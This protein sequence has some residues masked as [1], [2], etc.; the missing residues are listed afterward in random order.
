M[1]LNIAE[2]SYETGE[3]R[4]RY[5][6]YLSPDGAR[7]IRHGLFTEF[8]RNGQ[9]ASQGTYEDGFEEGS[10]QDFYESGQI[11]AEGTYYRGAEVG[12]LRYWNQDGIEEIPEN[13]G[14]GPLVE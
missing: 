14:D 9:L 11:A 5:A 6:R 13:R 3:V 12:I 1:D 2:I 4:F 8:H 10:W 7:W